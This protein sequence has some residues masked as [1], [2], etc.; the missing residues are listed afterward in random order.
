MKNFLANYVMP[1]PVPCVN[2][3]VVKV[4]LI[5]PADSFNVVYK[6]KHFFKCK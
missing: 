6:G 1:L 4:W 2:Q 3:V 5:V